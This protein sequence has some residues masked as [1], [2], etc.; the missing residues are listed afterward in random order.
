[1]LKLISAPSECVIGLPQVQALPSGDLENFAALAASVC[2][3]PMATIKFRTQGQALVK[4]RFGFDGIVPNGSDDFFNAVTEAQQVTVICDAAKDLRVSSHAYVVGAAAIRFFA[5]APIRDQGGNAIGA[6]CVFDSLKRPLGLSETQKCSLLGLA[7]RVSSDLLQMMAERVLSD[8]ERKLQVMAE[9]MPDLMFTAK[10]DGT[11]DYLNPRWRDFTGTDTD[12]L[13]EIGW[14]PHM[15]PAD[16]KEVRSRWKSCVEIGERYEAEHRML[17]HTGL[18]RWVLTKVAPVYGG[19]GYIQA[20]VGSCTDIHSRKQ[21]EAH[22]RATNERYRLAAKATQDAIWDWNLAT[23]EVEW[24][25]TS[26]AVLGHP[27]GMSWPATGRGWKDQIHPEDQAKVTKSIKRALKMGE[28]WEERYRFRRSDGTY[29]ELFDRGFVV[30][31]ALGRPVRMVGAAMNVSRKIAAERALKQSEERLHHALAAAKMVAWEIDGETG[32]VHRSANAPEM[33]GL[34]MFGTAYEMLKGAHNLDKKRLAEVFSGELR[35]ECEVRYNM[36][37]GQCRWLATRAS[38]TRAGRVVGVTYDVTQRKQIEAELLTSANID[39]LTGLP[40]RRSLANDFQAAIRDA[41]KFGAPLSLLLIDLDDFKDI[42]DTLGHD[43][44]D[45]LLKEFAMRLRAQFDPQHIVA[46]LGGDEFA[47]VLR[48]PF[49]RAQAE[50]FAHHVVMRM[51]EHDACAGPYPATRISAGLAHF[52]AHGRTRKDLMR[53]ADMAL[54]EAKK[55]GR[56]RAFIFSPRL[57]RR[58]EG[59][60]A[61]IKDVRRGLL[62]AEFFPVYQPQID[63]RSG[64]LVGLEALARWRHPDRGVLTPVH[65]LPAFEVDELSEELSRLMIH[66]IAADAAGWLSAGLAFGKV[67]LNLASGDF[68]NPHLAQMI[69]SAIADHAVPASMLDLEVTETVFLG[70]N[71]EQVRSAMDR[72]RAAGA[73]ISLDDFG[74]G[75]ASLTHLK[76]FPVDSIKIDQTFVK[77]LPA[78]NDRAIISAIIGLANGLGIALIAEGIELVAQAEWLFQK[79]CRTGQGYFFSKPVAAGAVPSLVETRYWMANRRKHF[80]LLATEGAGIN[81]QGRLTARVEGPRK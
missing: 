20:W 45:A 74:T 25:D 13:L 22:A 29:I 18:Y 28:K 64:R 40:N 6:I 51:Q 75:Y 80:Q 49:T 12:T 36:P 8:T 67:G 24:S 71:A 46:R 61:Q 5:G 16:A 77:G 4:A 53:N 72:L 79:G 42:N 70:S 27:D 15:H 37:D 35:G 68:K 62:A 78:E 32:S 41:R 7:K 48:E 26:A 31:D 43:A 63:L 14:L 34:P 76:Q 33:L 50:I 38:R 1:M 2:G 23:D 47:V 66:S 10:N 3:T 21:A 39:P 52:P 30:R 65:F 19:D 57:S 69:L 73:T 44:G 9:I 59:K 81:K 17:H 55:G 56:N 54:Y 11:L 58:V 60:V